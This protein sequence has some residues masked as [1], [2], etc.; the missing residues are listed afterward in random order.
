MV[1]APANPFRD[2]A[3]GRGR[4]LISSTFVPTRWRIWQFRDYERHFVPRVHRL[5]QARYDRLHPRAYA[6]AEETAITG[7]S[8][9]AIDEVSM[10]HGPLDAVLLG[11]RT[12]RPVKEP[13]SSSPTATQ[14]QGSEK[15]VDIRIDS[16][17]V[18]P[19]TR[20]RFECKRLG[21][22]HTVGVYLGPDG[23][24]CFLTGA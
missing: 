12:I 15:R 7:D 20:F 3:R 24:G 14:G 16:S 2:S 18:S 4:G 9:E 23:L 21:P 19:R 1:D 10:L 8:V 5:H 13:F 11:A 17:N 6:D 22:A